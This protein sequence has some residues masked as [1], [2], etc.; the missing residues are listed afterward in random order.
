[1]TEDRDITRDSTKKL[2]KYAVQRFNEGASLKQIAAEMGCTPRNVRRHLI[3]GGVKFAQGRKPKVL[4]V[5]LKGLYEKIRLKQTSYSILASEFGV[6]VN[7]IRLRIKEYER[8]A[9]HKQYESD[10]K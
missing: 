7:T 2:T 4:D 1:M 8:A 5:Q 6:S 10:K 3:R 9:R